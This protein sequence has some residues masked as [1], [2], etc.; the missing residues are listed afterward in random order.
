MPALATRQC[1]RC[2][3]RFATSSELDQHLRLDHRSAERRPDPQIGVLDRYDGT[4]PGAAS[5][6]SVSMRGFVLSMVVVAALIAFVAVASWH[7]AALLSVGL[8][9]A[10]T[11][12]ASL[13]RDRASDPGSE[14]SP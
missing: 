8:A 7:V 6:A 9:V 10:I 11:V 1:P 14:P 3:L 12:H 2:V 13:A 5:D 4:D